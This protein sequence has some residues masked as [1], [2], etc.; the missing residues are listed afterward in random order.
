MQRVRNRLSFQI[1]VLICAIIVT[2]TL[3]VGCVG[4]G[5]IDDYL[6]YDNYIQIQ[7]GMTYQEVVDILGGYDGTLDTSAGSG[8]YY[9]EYYYWSSEYGFEIITVGFENGRVCAKSQIGLD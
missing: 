5:S 1:I 8:G 3:F 4:E 7:N 9:L 6:T 2:S